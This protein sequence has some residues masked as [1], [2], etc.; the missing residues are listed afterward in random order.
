MDAVLGIDIVKAK[1]DVALQSADGK[2]ATQELRE[3]ADGLSRARRVADASRNRCTSTPR[4]HPARP[5]TL[6]R[7]G[8]Y[9]AGP[10]RQRRESGVIHAFAASS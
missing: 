1:F 3:Y 4:S 2:R 9:D 6:W 10:S 8:C 7:S 5:S